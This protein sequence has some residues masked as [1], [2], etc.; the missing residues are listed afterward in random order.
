MS[1]SVDVLRTFLD[2]PDRPQDALRFDQLHGFL[3][4]IANAPEVIMPS[5]WLPLVFGEPS[6]TFRDE[7][8]VR[9]ISGALLG[10]YNV[11]NE[12]S[13]NVAD[14]DEGGV[15]PGCRLLDDP[16]ANLEDDAP[17]TKWSR[18][19]IKGHMWLEE[20][21]SGCLAASG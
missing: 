19:F 6:P 1:S 14:T 11:V 18:G 9:A 8:E 10:E 7:D 4:A 21:W 12:F 16:T 13:T 17:V 5:E 15:P 2:H 20:T 3:F